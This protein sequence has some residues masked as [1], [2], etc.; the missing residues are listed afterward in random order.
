[1]SVSRRSTARQ[2]ERE[3]RLEAADAEGG[4]VELAELVLDGVRRVVGGDAVDRAVEEAG[5]AG[6]D[7]VRRA[8]RRVHLGV[9][10]VGE[11][12]G[13]FRRGPRGRPRG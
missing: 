5:D 8:Q 6:G 13:R 7:V 12:A 1:M 2:A 4:G 3:G 10:V 11:A 9:G